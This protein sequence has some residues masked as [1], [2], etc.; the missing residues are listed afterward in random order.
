V[1]V[2][3]ATIIAALFSAQLVCASPTEIV[4]LPAPTTTVAKQSRTTLKHRKRPLL[5]SPIPAAVPNIIALN[6]Q[7]PAG[8][9]NVS[10]R[11]RN[12]PISP[13][14]NNV[15]TVEGDLWR[16]KM[17][18]NDDEYHL[19]ISA[20]GASRTTDRIVAEIPPDPAYAG[21]RRQLVSMLPGSYIFKPKTSRDLAH[22]IPIRVTGYAFFDG[23]HW[24]SKSL[25]G[26]KHGTAF[27]A[28]LWEIHP[29]WKVESAH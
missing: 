19:E 27:T 29:V 7:L 18:D 9:K 22:S 8:V 23:H 1:T 12:A 13:I 10:V 28:T 6:Q 5:Y 21:T 24:S 15:Y 26:N 11:G 3:F 4:T 14:E 20:R 25:R 2:K 16:V 17:E